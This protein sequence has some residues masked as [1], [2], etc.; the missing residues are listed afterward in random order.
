MKCLGLA[1]GPRIAATVDAWRVY[2]N[3]HLGAGTNTLHRAVMSS[4]T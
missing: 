1:H 2:R 3:S 4:A